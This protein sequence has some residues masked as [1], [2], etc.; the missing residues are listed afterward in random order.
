MK[1]LIETAIG[2]SDEARETLQ[3]RGSTYVALCPSLYE[4]RTYGA[5]APEG[6]VPQL[7]KGNVPEWLEPIAVPGANGLKLWRVKP[8]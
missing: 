2:T 7:A 8:E 5:I 4:A 6:F 3:A 1:V